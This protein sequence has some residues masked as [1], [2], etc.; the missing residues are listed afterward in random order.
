MGTRDELIERLAIGLH[1]AYGT[2]IEDASEQLREF[3]RADVLC[4]IDG[5]VEFVAEW[6]E[7]HD[8]V[9]RD[10]IGDTTPAAWEWRA[11]MALPEGE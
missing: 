9:I 10:V 2:S 8:A 1:E 4:Q 7:E 6:L 3:T 11:G 5:V